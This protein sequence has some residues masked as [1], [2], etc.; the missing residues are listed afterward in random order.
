[1]QLTVLIEHSIHHFITPSPSGPCSKGSQSTI[2]PHWLSSYC[3]LFTLSH[4]PV[5]IAI[6]LSLSS[7]FP[8]T[9][10]IPVP[11]C[12]SCMIIKSCQLKEHACSYTD[13]RANR[14]TGDKK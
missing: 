1:M 11:P 3:V 4:S 10:P 14:V 12:S 13:Y 5:S 6:P 8:L 9:S 2:H 7:F